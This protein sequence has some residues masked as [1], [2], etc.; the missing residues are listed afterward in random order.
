MTKPFDGVSRRGLVAAGAA[1]SAGAMASMTSSQARAAGPSAL[2]GPPVSQAS[3]VA[4]TIASPRRS[5]IVYRTIGEFDISVESAS[6]K[7]QFGGRGVYSAETQ[8]SLWASFDIPG[9]VKISDVEFYATNTSGSTVYAGI[10]LWTADSGYFSYQLAQAPI[11][12]MS[13]QQAV[14]VDLPPEQN[15]PYPT[16]AKLFLTIFTPTNATVQW[17]GARVGML[18]GGEVSL[19]RS[20]IRVYDSREG[21][22][23]DP[24]QPRSI[25]IPELVAP[26]GTVG[27]LTQI[28]VLS[29]SSSGFVQV[30]S[31]KESRPDV[32][33]LRHPAT[34]SVF[35]VTCPLPTN[36]KLKIYSQR[37]AHV[38]VD[39][40][41]T[42]G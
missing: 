8:T 4:S 19:K 16:G 24:G 6:A 39:V 42:I 33:E 15:G 25:T 20:P 2:N 41:G 23:L 27:V 5:Y 17:N 35:S 38:L 1:M 13:T 10:W 9:G 30:W 22:K 32:G 34:P 26:N 36:R 37:S 40:I 12:S 7:R 21:S 3:P 11:P 28:S 31:A 29:P 14:L 18:G